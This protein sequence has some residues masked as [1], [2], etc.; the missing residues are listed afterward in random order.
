MKPEV[1]AAIVASV[2]ALLATFVS[3]V[4]VVRGER[5]SAHRQLFA[6]KINELGSCIYSQM[7][8]CS[9]YLKARSDASVKKWLD[10]A[11]EQQEKMK[12]LRLELRYPLWGIDDALHEATLITSWVTHYHTKPELAE[13]FLV[14]ANRLC[15]SL[16]S[17]IRYAYVHG[18]APNLSRRVWMAYRAWRMKRFRDKTKTMLGR[19]L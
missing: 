8:C 2:S 1:I 19:D 14:V 6:G 17:S 4:S 13:K 18:C 12:N 10:R 11:R 9:I 16:D 15:R 5:R 3:I 7:S